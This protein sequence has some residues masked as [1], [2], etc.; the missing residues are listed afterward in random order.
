MIEWYMAECPI[1]GQKTR[2]KKSEKDGWFPLFL[3]EHY[4]GAS[5]ADSG[6][7]MF[8]FCSGLVTAKKEIVDY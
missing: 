6:E 8:A 7:V 1:C 2:L 3:C 5:T 4:E